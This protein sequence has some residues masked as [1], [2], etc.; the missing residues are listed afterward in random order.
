MAT[1][2]LEAAA[3]F[4]GA[5]AD[6]GN[7]VRPIF[8]DTDTEAVLIYDVTNSRW[9]PIAQ[10]QALSLTASAT[11]ATVNASRTH[12]VNAAAGLTLTLPTAAGAGT[13]FRISV[14]T[15]LTSVSIIINT[16]GSDAFYGGVHI[17]DTGDT[18]PATNDFF[19][20]VAGTSVH[21]TLAQSAG[22]GKIGD[23]VEITDVG[24]L[25]WAVRGQLSGELDPTTPW[26]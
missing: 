6:V 14:G 16:A 18:T 25:K 15:L 2:Y 22:A 4:P 20:A 1:K 21:L 10:P 8:V 12:I 24:L 26:S 17:N 9:V 11:L 3:D 5:V 19:P 7:N 23:W 13:K